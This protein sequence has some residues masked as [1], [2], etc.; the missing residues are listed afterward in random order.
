MKVYLCSPTL[1]TC[2]RA[3]GSSGG[4]QSGAADVC[5]RGCSSPQF[6]LGERRSPP[7]RKHWGAHH[8]S[9]WRAHNRQRAGKLNSFCASDFHL[10]LSP[11][12]FYQICGRSSVIKIYVFSVCCPPSTSLKMLA[13]I[14]ASPQTKSART[15]GQ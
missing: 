15:E 1:H 9:L 14:S 13:G 5:G 7:H 11:F 3:G 6:A 10:H 12:T 8:P 2:W 4:K